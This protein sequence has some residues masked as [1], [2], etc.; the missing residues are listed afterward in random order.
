MGL[1]DKLLGTDKRNPN[2]N[3]ETQV[4]GYPIDSAWKERLQGAKILSEHDMFAADEIFEE[5][6]D[7]T[8]DPEA[9]RLAIISKISFFHMNESM[10]DQYPESVYDS[11]AEI[12]KTIEWIEILENTSKKKIDGE[13]VERKEWLARCY[14]LKGKFLYY[15]DQKGVATTATLKKGMELGSNKSKLYLALA[16][17]DKAQELANSFDVASIKSNY[18]KKL[19][20]EIDSIERR[21]NDYYSNIVEL[22]EDYVSNYS[23]I[24]AT[25]HELSNACRILSLS[26]ENGYGVVRNYKKAEWFKGIADREKEKWDTKIQ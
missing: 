3:E 17:L 26:Y 19:Q 22:L 8:H 13:A 18:S 16:Y 4:N 1:L 2:I 14:E 7:N 5:I 15:L 25:A 23:E 10:F 21:I 6:A 9:L 24:G 20:K 12:D 11:I